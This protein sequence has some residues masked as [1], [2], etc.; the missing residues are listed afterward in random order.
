MLF[1]A[2]SSAGLRRFIPDVIA[3]VMYG[4]AIAPTRPRTPP[5]AYEA[6]EGALAASVDAMLCWPLYDARSS[7]RVAISMLRDHGHALIQARLYTN[8]KRDA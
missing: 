3:F 7:S 2:A 4:A 5:V 1:N 8:N 6:A